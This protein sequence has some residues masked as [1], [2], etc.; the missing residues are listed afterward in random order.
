MKPTSS[1]ASSARA[2]GL[3]SLPPAKPASD[4]VPASFDGADWGSIEPLAVEL[5]KREL[6]SAADIERWLLDRS[7]FDAACSEA[8]I[9]LYIAMTCHTDDDAVAAAYTRHLEDIDPKLRQL[10]FDLSKR[11]VEAAARHPLDPRRYGVLLRDSR[12]EVELF[13]EEN[14][15]LFTEHEKLGQRYQQ[16]IGAMTVR[17]GGEERTLPQ[18]AKE[19]MATERAVRESAFRAV[20][21]RRLRDRDEIDDIYDRMLALRARIASNTGFENYRDYSFKAR[22]RF[23]YTPAH[24]FALHGAVEKHIVPLTRVTA[25]RRR[26]AMGVSAMRPWDVAVDQH[27]RPPLKPFTNGDDLLERCR[28]VFDRMDPALSRFFRALG[29][30]G[31]PARGFDLDSRKGKAPGGYQAMRDRERTPFIFMNAAG[32]QRDVETLVHEAGHAFHA[33][34]ARDEPLVWYRE[35]P[36]EFCEVASM[37]MELLTAPFFDEFYSTAEELGRAKRDQIEGHALATLPWIAQVDAFQHWTHTNPGHSR[38]ERNRAWLE[39]DQRFGAGVSWEGLEDERAWQWHKQLHLFTHPF[40]YIEYGIARLGSMGLWLVAIEQG[41]PEALRRYE[42]GLSLGGSRP[43][44]EL[45]E[46]AG[47]PF[48]FGD[49]IVERLARAAERE[50]AKLPG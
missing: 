24:C 44:P 25:E 40:Y 1:P 32:V 16:L 35:A 49:A 11:L 39:L 18:M 12:A 8:R 13:R 7:E 20:A 4:F 33:L 19:Q 17:F 45:F 23:D 21:E 46:A 28:R 38:A 26:R 48:E 50:L 30:N 3:V 29:E 5:L 47:L 6:K 34:F 42:R 37:T 36:T 9:D 22:R 41:L 15:P 10:S 2:E 27:G 43:L 14:L 31:A